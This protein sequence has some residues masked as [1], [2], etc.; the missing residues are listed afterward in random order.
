[1]RAEGDTSDEEKQIQSPAYDEII[2]MLECANVNQQRQFASP[3]QQTTRSNRMGVLPVPS[4]LRV[5]EDLV[6]EDAGSLGL[7][8]FPIELNVN[9]EADEEAKLPKSGRALMISRNGEEQAWL[10]EPLTDRIKAAFETLK[11]ERNE[12]GLRQPEDSG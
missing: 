6:W 7:K 1:M 8:L 12:S 9:L 11:I 10:V 5:L 2:P 4:G 3:L